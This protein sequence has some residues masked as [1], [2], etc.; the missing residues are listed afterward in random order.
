MTLR[1]SFKCSAD[2]SNQLLDLKS[3]IEQRIKS[4]ETETVNI[5]KKITDLAAELHAAT[6]DYKKKEIRN[7]L[8]PL[9]RR[10]KI[11]EKRLDFYRTE[12][13]NVDLLT[14]AA[15]IGT[16]KKTEPSQTPYVRSNLKSLTLIDDDIS[17]YNE[18][19]LLKEINSINDMI[20][21]LDPLPDNDDMYRKEMKELEKEFLAI[22]VPLTDILTEFDVTTLTQ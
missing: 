17:K 3:T 18:V 2:D 16:E 5:K 19:S 21:E 10:K 4:F 13:Y 9:L 12:L 7:K 15:N 6:T 22:Q 20:N 1:Q 8:L 11:I 14:F